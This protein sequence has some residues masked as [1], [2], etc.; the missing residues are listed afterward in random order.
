MVGASDG[1]SVGAGGGVM[2]GKVAG[3]VV[4]SE[5]VTIGW[6][7]SGYSEAS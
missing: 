6:Y 3:L 2:G 5:A 1:G 7:Q 4:G